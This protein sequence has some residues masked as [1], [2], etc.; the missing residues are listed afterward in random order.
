M[1]V[2]V[3]VFSGLTGYFGQKDDLHFGREALNVHFFLEE[4]LTMLPHRLPSES[5]EYLTHSFIFLLLHLVI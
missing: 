3:L 5:G 2:F 1:Q 4:D